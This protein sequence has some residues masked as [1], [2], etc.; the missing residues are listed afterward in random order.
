MLHV[1]K[2]DQVLVLVGKDR[3]RTGRVLRI[4]P[5]RGRAVVEN[6]NVI[7]RHTR[8]NPQRNIKGGIVERES[9]LKISNPQRNIKGG[10]VE[11]ESPLKISNLMVI[12]RECS[13]P[14]RVGYSLLSDGNKVRVC[15]KCGGTIDK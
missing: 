3:G 4:L 14:T 9:P 8:P 2:N 11:R 5:S 15:R 6:V 1:K 7:R 12:C 13:K 10:I